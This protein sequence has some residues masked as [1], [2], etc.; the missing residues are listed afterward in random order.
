MEM[1][2]AEWNEAVFRGRVQPL[3]MVFSR[4][5]KWAKGILLWESAVEPE[6]ASKLS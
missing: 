4:S 1:S 5:G 2:E 3:W 6:R